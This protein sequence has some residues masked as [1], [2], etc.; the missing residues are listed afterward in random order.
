M[1]DIRFAPRKSFE[2]ML[3]YTV[4]PTFDLVLEQE[5][6]GVIFGKRKIPPYKG[7]W[8]LPGLR[9]LK[10]EGINDTLERIAK[11]EVGANINPDER[12]FLG[13]YVGKFRT[14]HNRQDLSTGYYLRVP[15]EEKIVMNPQ[16]FSDIAV[17]RKL[18]EHTGAM[19]AFYF[20]KYVELKRLAERVAK[21]VGYRFKT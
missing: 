12:V 18:P 4:I 16:H 9:M 20:Q 8:A 2:Q 5:G 11:Q 14:E 15:Y 21:A 1:K 6:R 13:Q 19:Y 10:S 3:K 7:K 17:T